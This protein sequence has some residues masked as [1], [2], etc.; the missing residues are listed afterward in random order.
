M[1]NIIRGATRGL[2]FAVRSRAVHIERRV[3]LYYV[4]LIR[5]GGQNHRTPVLMYK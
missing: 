3:E 4:L 2:P 1:Y 5:R